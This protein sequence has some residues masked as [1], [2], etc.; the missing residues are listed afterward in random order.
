MMG[1]LVQ[2]IG[3]ALAS[4]RQRLGANLLVILTMA[5]GI[6]LATSS[7]SLADALLLRPFPYAQPE[8]L[9]RLDTRL[10]SGVEEARGV[11]IED[12]KDWLE[13]QRSLTGLAAYIQFDNN[14]TDGGTTRAIKMTFTNPALFTL[15]GIQPLLGRTFTEAEDMEGGPVRQLVLSHGLWQSQFG[16]DTGVLG[17][18]VRLR[19]DSYTVIGVM[20]SDFRYPGRSDV[21]VPL[22]ARY[23]SYANAFW[24]ARDARLH[25]VLARLRP[26]VSLDQAQADLGRIAAELAQSYPDSNRGVTAKVTSLRE[27][28]AGNLRPYV[29][30][31]MAASLC[32]LLIAVLNVSSLLLARATGREREMAIHSALGASTARVMGRILAESVMLACAGGVLGAALAYG[33]IRVLPSWL[34]SDLPAWI[35]FEMDWRVLLFSAVVWLV[36]GLLFGFAP[37]LRLA[38]LDLYASLKD[39]A[40]GSAVR[41]LRS[42]SFLVAAE[43]GFSVLLLIAAGLLVRSFVHLQQAATGLQANQ[44]LAVRV[45][46]FVSG[47]PF[48]ELASLYGADHREFERRFAQLPGVQAVG[49]SYYVPMEAQVR[50]R[51]QASLYVKGTDLR[52]QERQLPAIGTDVTPGFFDALRIPILEGRACTEADA[53]SSAVAAAIVSKT[54]AETL[55]P[56]RN[57]IGQQLRWGKGSDINPWLTVVGVAGDTRWSAFETGRNLEVYTCSRQWAT[58]AMTFFLHTAGNPDAL[59]PEIRRIVREVSPDTAVVYARRFPDLI[60]ESIW[61]PRVWSVV[62]AGFALFAVVLS[63]LG[64]FGILNYFVAQRTREIGVRLAIGASRRDVLSLI[65]RRGLLWTALGVI[66]ALGLAAASGGWLAPLL[67][68]VAAH[69]AATYLTVTAGVVTCAGLACL[70]P[71]W[72]AA[73]VDPNI[74]LRNE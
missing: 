7:Y 49:G 59:V 67:H 30:L 24:R 57:P 53:P 71:A 31:L 3:R 25:S 55:W 19:G 54:A 50:E 37:A 69:D 72:R 42:L 36:T 2:V 73:Q 23:A 13:R 35:R 14:L 64:L 45:S 41:G 34:P 15:L 48:S 18:T 39:G 38:R 40:K 63:G 11:S 62:L 60:A 46:R 26:G 43:V 65:L 22:M 33:L 68:G 44:L 8:G 5:L 1:T 51:S 17:R 6:G 16:S 12:A 47:K 10:T 9:V 58:L 20:P 56:G 32:V 29:I 21:W 70:L 61:Q 4:L 66:P 28:E 27:A 52:D 74:A